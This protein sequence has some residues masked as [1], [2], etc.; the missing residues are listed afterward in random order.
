MLYSKQLEVNSVVGSLAS[1]LQSSGLQFKYGDIESPSEKSSPQSLHAK[2]W[3]SRPQTL[4]KGTGRYSWWDSAIDVSM[5]LIPIPF[6]LLATAVI[7]VN[8]REVNDHQFK[9]LDQSIKGVYNSALTFY[10]ELC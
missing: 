3:P 6:F 2:P 4:S 10:L 5:I 9:L 7:I 8:G 1:P